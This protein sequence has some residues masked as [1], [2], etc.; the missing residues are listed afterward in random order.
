MTTCNNGVARTLPLSVHASQARTLVAA[1]REAG[2]EDQESLEISLESE[3]DL[4][5]ALGEAVAR[6]ADIEAMIGALDRRAEEIGARK[7]VLK[8]RAERVRGAVVSALELAGVRSVPTPEG[9]VY[10]IAV[11]PSVRIFDEACIPEA[12]M[13]A[14]TTVTPDRAAIGRALAAGQNVP[15]ACLGNGGV[16]LGVRR[17]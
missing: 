16:S 5:A 7:V 4:P 13:K 14:K 6:L 15:G 17:S 11:R 9:C 1:L 8:E 2:I 12:F 3:T 10:T